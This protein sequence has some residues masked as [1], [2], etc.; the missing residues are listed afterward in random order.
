[1]RKEEYSEKTLF[2]CQFT[3]N[4]AWNRTAENPGLCG[5]TTATNSLINPVMKV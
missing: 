4:C 2:Q 3:A 1:M 5:E